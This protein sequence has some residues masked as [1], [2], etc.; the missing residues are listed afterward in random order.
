[1]KN[2]VYQ[3]VEKKNEDYGAF[4]RTTNE[5]NH[6]QSNIL[7]NKSKVIYEKFTSES[8]RFAY[9]ECNDKL[10]PAA[11][12]INSRFRKD[13]GMQLTDISRFYQENGNILLIGEGGAGKTTSLLAAW[14]KMIDLYDTLHYIPLYIP[15]NEANKTIKGEEESFIQKYINDTYKVKAS[16][17]NDLVSD[18]SQRGEK[19]FLLL[20]GFNEITDRNKQIA[21]AKEIK[22]MGDYD[23][24][25]IIMTSRFDFLSTYEMEGFHK[26][27]ILPLDETV[28]KNY[29]VETE[30]PVENA[31]IAILSNPMILTLYANMCLI[32][33]MISESMS[34]PFFKN[35]TKGEVIANFLM[36]QIGKS[37]SVEDISATYL[38]YITLF[39]V[40]PYIAYLIEKK[41]RFD[42]SFSNLNS[43]IRDALEH[44]CSEM[45]YYFARDL[46]CL[47]SY[48]PFKLKVS[49]DTIS[50]IS[51]LLLEDF[52]VLQC[53]ERVLYFR[54]QYFRD[55][56]SALFI[57]NDC[58]MFIRKGG[59]LTSLGE[60]ILPEYISSFIGDLKQEYVIETTNQEDFFFSL[61][62]RITEARVDN[63][64]IIINNIIG[65]LILAKNKNL[66]R[67]DLTKLDLSKVSLNGV[68]F[69]TGRNSASFNN[70]LIAERTFLPQGHIGQVRSAVYSPDSRIILSAG[71]TTV[72]EWDNVT[73]LCVQ[74]YEG[75]TNL[76]NSACFHP[77]GKYILSAA[78]DNTVRE[79]FASVS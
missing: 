71:D 52:A 49:S 13:N 72:K 39:V 48:Y 7:F 51:K 57:C 29:L 23:T 68:I 21:V 79:Y 55:F 59:K 47:S 22:R 8:G 33:E 77:S 65:I 73:G 18:S 56:F 70:A 74:T 3:S 42:L 30:I 38:N 40:C 19:V 64:D 2:K 60:R 26:Y 31:P 35:R 61:T 27:S 9:F 75:H 15:L 12:P 1:M 37:F 46:Y 43:V 36:C 53:E 10:F 63:S 62:R 11:R 50:S 25:R 34:L 6:R 67:M 41:G 5:K 54:H 44:S 78:N 4:L 14:K 69:S 58:E 24:F 66:S 76:V 28:I 45:D 17:M 32:K 20:D 16:E